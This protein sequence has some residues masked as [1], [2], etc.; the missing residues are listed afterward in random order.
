M[1]T[2]YPVVATALSAVLLCG[3]L[4]YNPHLITEAD[5]DPSVT[6]V[7]ESKAYH[8]GNLPFV[9]PET[10]TEETAVAEMTTEIPTAAE[11]TTA[12]STTKASA[13]TEAPTEPPT[14]PSTK[15]QESEIHTTGK[16]TP[17][18]ETTV[19]ERTVYGSAGRLNIPSVGISVPLNFARLGIDDVQRIVDA[20]DSAAY[21]WF[22]DVMPVVADHNNQGFSTLH[23]VQKGDVAF[24]ANA[25]GGVGKYVCNCVCYGTNTG[26]DIL[27]SDGYSIAGTVTADLIMYTCC[28]GWQN[29]LLTY[30]K[31]I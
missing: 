24:V 4:R 9:P 3:C 23:R 21:F 31:A 30:W 25:D 14:E 22:R 13:V 7:S 1:K 12:A 8:I 18:N 6:K 11:T 5:T 2:V 17:K 20:S 27:D 29:I 10:T 15:K 26:T 19:S 28:N 16:E